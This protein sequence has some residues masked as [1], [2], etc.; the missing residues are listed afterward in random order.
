MDV[1]QGQDLCIA[2]ILTE[3]KLLL[4]IK[5]VAS[6]MNDMIRVGI[7]VEEVYIFLLGMNSLLYS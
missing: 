5:Y 7:K 3:Q 6:N 2:K 4:L 1:K